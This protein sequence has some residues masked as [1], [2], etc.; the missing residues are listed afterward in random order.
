MIITD[1][2]EPSGLSIY[3]DQIFISDTNNHCIKIYNKINKKIE[4]VGNFLLFFNFYFFLF[5]YSLN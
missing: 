3:N 4:K 2:N 1:L 5:F